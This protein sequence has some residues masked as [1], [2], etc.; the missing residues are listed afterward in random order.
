MMNQMQSSSSGTR[1]PVC[2]MGIDEKSARKVEYNGQTYLVA[3]DDCK[4]RFQADPARYAGKAADLDSTSSHGHH[5]EDPARGS[6][7]HGSC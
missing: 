1:C 6:G 3:S 4:A 7:G 5:V 2:G